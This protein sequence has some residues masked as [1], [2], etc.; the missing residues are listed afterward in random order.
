MSDGHAHGIPDSLGLIGT[1][2][3]TKNRAEEE[4]VN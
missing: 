4:V 3:S 2:G 1:M